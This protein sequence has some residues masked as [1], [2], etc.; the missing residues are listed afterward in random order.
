METRSFTHKQFINA[1]N[2]LGGNLTA[3][4]NHLF[5]D[6]KTVYNY[7]YANPE[8]KEAVDKARYEFKDRIV[9]M[10]E[11][12]LESFL[13]DRHWYATKYVL[14]TQG[15]KK[16]YGNNTKLE[17]DQKLEVKANPEQLDQFNAILDQWVNTNDAT[18]SSE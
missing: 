2:L 18:S 12:N 3:V 8:L 15:R 16:G 13:E 14:D 9:D 4:A 11:E 10:A 6:R 17:I 1:V 7:L 5:C